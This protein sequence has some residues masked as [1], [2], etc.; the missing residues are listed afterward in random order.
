MER[1]IGPAKKLPD[2]GQH[3]GEGLYEAE[4]DYLLREEW[5]RNAE[6]ILWRRSKLGLHLSRSVQDRLA[7]WLS[8]RREAARPEPRRAEAP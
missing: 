1:L 7:D 3:L 5:A 2:L 6:D 8:G 4:V